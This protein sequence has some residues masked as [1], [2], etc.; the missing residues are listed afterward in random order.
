MNRDPFQPLGKP[1]GRRIDSSNISTERLRA[2]VITNRPEVRMAETALTLAK[3]KLELAKREWI[4][5]PALSV[6]AQRYNGASQA[7]SEIAV[8]IS[9]TLPWLNGKK[10][11]AEEKEAGHYAACFH[12]DRVAAA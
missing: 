1:G 10:Y 11:R 2:L 4:P 9:V 5:D 12:S 6:Q 7:A 8:G 3:A